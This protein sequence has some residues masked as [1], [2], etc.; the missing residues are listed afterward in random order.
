MARWPSGRPAGTAIHHLVLTDG[1]KGTWDPDRDQASLVALRQDEQRRAA[2]LLGGGDV[3]FLGWTDGELRNGAR[4]PVG[5][6]PV[7]SHRPSR[8]R[9]RATTPGAVTGSIRT[10]ATPG[11]SSPTPSWP[12]VTRTSSPIRGSRRTAPSALLLWEADEP[13]HVEDVADFVETKI[14]ALLAHESQYESTMGIDP[15]RP[16][17]LR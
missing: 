16:R 7:D 12:P 10:T 8:C 2:A 14:A 13:N 6:L 4:A 11:S 15:A 1:A 3:D 9:P 17:P 5:G